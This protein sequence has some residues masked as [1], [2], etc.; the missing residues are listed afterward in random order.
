MSCPDC[1]GPVQYRPVAELWECSNLLDL[2][3]WASGMPPPAPLVHVVELDLG[4]AR[5]V[6]ASL[7]PALARRLRGEPPD[8]AA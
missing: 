6:A 8:G 7:Q 2:C 4:A 5:D 3:G 1:G